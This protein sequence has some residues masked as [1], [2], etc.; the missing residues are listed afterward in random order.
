MI[1]IATG[2][3]NSFE[4]LK[5]LE[6]DEEIKEIDISVNCFMNCRECGLTFTI[7]RNGGNMTYCV[8]EHRNSDEII[9]NGKENWTFLTEDLPYKSNNKYDYIESVGYGQY[10]EAFR[11]LR[12]LILKTA[13][14]E[15]LK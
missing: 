15:G 3:K 1:H 12:G 6:A 11:V 10:E 9:I 5:L 8:Y 14:I 7:Q 13:C 4:V 2:L